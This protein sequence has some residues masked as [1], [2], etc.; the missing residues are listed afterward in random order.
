MHEYFDDYPQ[1]KMVTGLFSDRASAERAY[2]ACT[3]AAMA[4]TT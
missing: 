4:V 3:P 2:E 1:G